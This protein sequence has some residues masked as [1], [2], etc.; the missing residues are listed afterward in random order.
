MY[1]KLCQTSTSDVSMGLLGVAQI[2]MSSTYMQKTS[3]VSTLNKYI[4]GQVRPKLTLF[5]SV[6]FGLSLVGFCVRGRVGW[7]DAGLH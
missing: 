3:Q 5:F 4:G 2:N 1:S 7:K 6:V